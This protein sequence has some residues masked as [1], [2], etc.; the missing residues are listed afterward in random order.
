MIFRGSVCS[1]HLTITQ[2]DVSEWLI[3][4]SRSLK[5]IQKLNLSDE[6][7]FLPWLIF[8]TNF[9]G[10]RQQRVTEAEW[11][12]NVCL[13]PKMKLYPCSCI[14]F[15]VILAR[16]YISSGS[17]TE[18]GGFTSK[19]AR[20]GIETF[21]SLSSPNFPP[22][23][24]RFRAANFKKQKV[25]RKPC[26]E[27][28]SRKLLCYHGGVNNGTTTNTLIDSHNSAS[29]RNGWCSKGCQLFYFHQLLVLRIKILC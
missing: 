16:E 14:D 1:M 25:N 4:G 23:R 8:N 5:Y 29:Q 15:I 9:L 26:G 6:R 27:L 21:H 22:Y 11:E 18:S 2:Y 3:F 13:F 28:K 10:I 7:L 12:R 19:Y 17:S 24:R 20:G